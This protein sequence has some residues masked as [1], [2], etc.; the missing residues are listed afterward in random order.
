MNSYSLTV[1]TWE[2]ASLSMYN[3]LF[4]SNWIHRWKNLHKN[5]R[6]YIVFFK[7]KLYNFTKFN[8]ILLKLWMCIDFWMRASSITFDAS[9]WNYRNKQEKKLFDF[10]YS[11]LYAYWIFNDHN[12][13]VDLGMNFDKEDSSIWLDLWSKLWRKTSKKRNERY[14]S[15]EDQEELLVYNIIYGRINNRAFVFY[16]ICINFVNFLKKNL[17]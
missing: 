3:Y 4:L 14:F 8:G 6:G 13:E 12:W 9:P 5:K 15:K 16:P 7:S 11:T 10:F 1:Y 2:F 17:L